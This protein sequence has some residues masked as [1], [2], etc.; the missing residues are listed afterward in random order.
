MFI[1]GVYTSHDVLLF[2][3]T[4]CKKLQKKRLPRKNSKHKGMKTNKKCSLENF[5]FSEKRVLAWNLD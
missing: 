4:G 5:E 2:C 3:R 1:D